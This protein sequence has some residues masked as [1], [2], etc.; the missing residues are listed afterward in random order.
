[1]IADINMA[2]ER[3]YKFDEKIRSCLWYRIANNIR[4][5]FSG[6]RHIDKYM[7]ILKGSECDFAEQLRFV[8]NHPSDSQPGD[9][10]SKQWIVAKALDENLRFVQLRNVRKCTSNFSIQKTL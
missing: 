7:L 10:L 2:P 6:R 9:L 1:M 3:L 4:R 5:A 8:I